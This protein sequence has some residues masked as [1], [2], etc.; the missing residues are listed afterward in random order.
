MS[1]IT[2]SLTISSDNGKSATVDIPT[3]LHYSPEAISQ[4]E[5]FHDVDGRLEI[6]NMVKDRLIE[7]IKSGLSEAIDSTLHQIL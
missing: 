7:S 5:E 4:L 1:K 3:K 6:S 2:I